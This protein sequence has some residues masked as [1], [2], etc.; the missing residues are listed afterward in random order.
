MVETQ[1]PQ[2]DAPQPRYSGKAR[3]YIVHAY[4]IFEQ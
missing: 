4:S 3:W 2:S 1:E